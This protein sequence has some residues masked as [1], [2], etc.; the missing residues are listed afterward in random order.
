[1]PRHKSRHEFHI[2]TDLY[3]FP[4]V[5]LFNITRMIA[6]AH[7]FGEVRGGAESKS[8]GTESVN[9]AKFGEAKSEIGS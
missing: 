8:I 9:A 5:H 4:V 2:N 3:L 6:I 7:D 1:M